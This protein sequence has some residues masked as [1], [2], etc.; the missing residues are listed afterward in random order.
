MIE[1]GSQNE[2]PKNDFFEVFKGLDPMVPQG[3]PQDPPGTSPGPFQDVKSD[4]K[5]SK[6]E[7]RG[8]PK[9]IRS[10]KN[11]SEHQSC[12]LFASICFWIIFGS[13]FPM[14]SPWFSD[15]VPCFCHDFSM[16]VL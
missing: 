5:G 4:A 9:S 16:V 12:K 14:V 15:F 3:A 2:A 10:D 1:K 7:S 11:G 6:M 8:H 13:Y